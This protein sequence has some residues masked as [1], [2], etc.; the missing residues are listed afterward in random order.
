MTPIM[1]C[2]YPTTVVLIDDDF[3]M[4]KNLVP[5]LDLEDKP[6]KAFHDAHEGLAFI[7]QDQYRE[8]FVDRLAACDEGFEGDS[9]SFSPRCLLRELKSPKRFEQVSVLVVDYEMPGM[10]GID[11]CKKIEN[12][13]V[14]KI[15]LTG[16]ADENVAVEAFNKGLICSYIRK[17]APNFQEQLQDAV[18]R[19]QQD[20][21]RELFY[22]P[23]Q[24]LKKRPESTALV[25]PVF[26]HYFNQLIE[27]DRIQEFYLAE[28]T[29]S[30]L[31]VGPDQKLYSL[32]TLDDGLINAFLESRCVEALEP[33]YI[34]A[35][36]KRDF[37]PCYYNPFKAPYLETNELKNF[38]HEPIVLKGEKKSFYTV[39]GQ[40]FIQI[41]S[42]DIVSWNSVKKLKAS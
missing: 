23:L 1:P 5:G 15:L 38:L 13:F 28:S 14:K 8:T 19:A 36:E 10:N 31:M 11:L 30:F 26:I 33:E 20:Y 6:H 34:L 25:D 40:G 2:F 12:P 41:S 39:F 24:T 18:I 4:L 42:Q 16:V 9:L 32:I 21:F 22:F 37:V 7:N 17:H 27:K 35:L 3:F 29:G